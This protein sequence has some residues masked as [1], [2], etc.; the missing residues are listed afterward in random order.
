MRKNRPPLPV[1]RRSEEG[2]GSIGVRYVL[3]R[4]DRGSSNSANRAPR[5][6]GC[7]ANCACAGICAN[8]RA[9][10]RSLHCAAP[11]KRPSEK[12]AQV[13]L[14]RVLLL[15]VLL[16]NNLDDTARSRFDQNCATIHHR[17]SMFAYTI[18][19]RHIVVGNAFFR[20]NCTNSQVFPIFV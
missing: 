9:S 10:A 11:E 1:M 6:E 20:Q 19:R 5:N 8:I 12:T 17:V 14:L 18:L 13:L 7:R 2:T 15:Q 4:R 3:P 16:L